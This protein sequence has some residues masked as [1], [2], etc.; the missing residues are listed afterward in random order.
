MFHLMTNVVLIGFKFTS[1]DLIY[2]VRNI[3]VLQKIINGAFNHNNMITFIV[4]ATA[5]V[6]LANGR[7]AAAKLTAPVQVA[8]AVVTAIGTRENPMLANMA[9]SPDTS[10]IFNDVD[11]SFPLTTLLSPPP[12]Q[13]KP[14]A[15]KDL[16]QQQQQTSL[17]SP[18][19]DNLNRVS[20]ISWY[21]KPKNLTK[22]S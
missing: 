12:F 10:D 16:Q 14:V 2:R 19:D 9:T 11:L 3:I 21:N 15:A 17:T 6:L 22:A 4:V 18:N 20:L 5:A 1:T 13:T 8:E 7:A